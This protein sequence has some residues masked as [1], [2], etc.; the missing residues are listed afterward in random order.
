M[1]VRCLRVT[2][3]AASPLAFAAMAHGQGLQDR[4]PTPYQQRQ[5][6][7]P[8]QQPQ[9][10]SSPPAEQPAARPAVAQSPARPT[11]TAPAKP[12]AAASVPVSAQAIRHAEPPRVIVCG[13]VF[14]K[15]TS[16]LKLAQMYEAQNITYTEVDGPEGSKLMASVLYPHD[17]KRRLEVL[18]QNDAMR[19]D[20]SVISINGQST[21]IAPKSLKL[22]VPL[23]TLE[24]LNGK[25]FKLSGL[26]VSDWMGG[27]LAILPGGC[28][29][30]MKLAPDPKTPADARSQVSSDKE[31]MSSDPVIRAA[32]PTVQE[33]TIGYP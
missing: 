17:P 27:G 24:K 20:L 30:G 25:P 6:E 21:W 3:L 11:A 8:L 1:M 33:I 14:A 7:T 29:M 13:G 31:F 26:D 15:D 22:G 10:Q 16:H 9:T 12:A 2:V 4:W 32:K 5:M 23:A 19:S 28:T 18:W